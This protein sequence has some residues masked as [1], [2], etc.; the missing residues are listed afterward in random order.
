MLSQGTGQSPSG[1]DVIGLQAQQ[2]VTNKGT[3]MTPLREEEERAELARLFHEVMQQNE[4]LERE[5]QKT[6]MLQKRIQERDAHRDRQKSMAS[7]SSV[8]VVPK[9]LGDTFDGVLNWGLGLFAPT[10]S[11]PTLQAKSEQQSRTPPQGS[12]SKKIT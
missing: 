12:R 6:S 3:M 7:S 2:D 4:E 8:G 5:L 10:S 1:L 9:N 11:P